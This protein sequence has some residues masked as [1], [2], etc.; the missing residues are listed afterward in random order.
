MV[1]V[2]PSSVEEDD[3]AWSAAMEGWEGYVLRMSGNA[4]NRIEVTEDELPKLVK[5]RRPFWQA[6][7]RDGVALFGKPLVDVMVRTRA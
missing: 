2:R 4:I 3:P 5:S 6:I 1:V 7:R